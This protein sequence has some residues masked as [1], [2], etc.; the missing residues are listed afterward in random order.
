MGRTKLSHKALNASAGQP[1][2]DAGV[3]FE[4]FVT[5][6]TLEYFYKWDTK[7]SKLTNSASIASAISDETGTGNLV[8]NTSPTFNTNIT[9]PVIIGGSSTTSSII[10]RTT[11]GVGTTGADHV[12]QV[13]NNGGTEA[14]RILN[15]GNVVVTGTISGSNLSGI[16]TGDQ[17]LAPY[18]LSATAASTYQPLDSDLTA[19]AALTTNSF[20]L[21]LLT[22]TSAEN[23]RTYIGASQIPERKY[24]SSGIY[25]YC[26]V[27]PSGSLES[28]SVWKI[29][30]LTIDSSGTVT[31][32]NCATSVAWTDYLTASYSTCV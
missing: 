9:T 15:N 2:V 17:N 24:A 10:Y 16:N 28:A 18:L 4:Q 25:S 11:T 20:G 5:P 19:I 13:G 12:F 29:T 23:V 26:G 32:T 7:Q 3:D 21:G 8:F 22:Q 31:D 27:A 14:M 30:R 1:S 6:N